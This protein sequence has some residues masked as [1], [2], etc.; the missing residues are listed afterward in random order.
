M[1]KKRKKI[2]KLK[3]ALVD[4]ADGDAQLGTPSLVLLPSRN[5]PFKV[6][7]KIHKIT[8]T[9]EGSYKELDPD[10]FSAE[11]GEFKLYDDERNVLYFPAIS[12]VL[13]AEKKYPDLKDHQLFAPLFMVVNKKDIEIFGQIIDMLET[14][15]FEKKEEN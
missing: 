4:W 6:D 15:D 2:D 7:E 13:Y 14:N 8:L 11:D 1:A 12:K 10:F 9:R 5:Y 3:N